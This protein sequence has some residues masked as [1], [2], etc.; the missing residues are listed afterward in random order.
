MS[1][2][3]SLV[4]F[5]Q[6]HK[7]SRYFGHWHPIPLLPS[8]VSLIKIKEAGRLVHLSNMACIFSY[9]E[10]PTVHCDF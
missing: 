5:K 2:L 10:T 8:T 6:V 7:L 3:G 9:D 4:S 1:S